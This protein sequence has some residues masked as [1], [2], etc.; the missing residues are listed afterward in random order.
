MTEWNYPHDTDRWNIWHDDWGWYSFYLTC[1]NGWAR[2]LLNRWIRH[3]AEGVGNA[4]M[5]INQ[6]TKPNQIKPAFRPIHVKRQEGTRIC[7]NEFTDASGP[8]REGGNNIYF[9]EKTTMKSSDGMV[10]FED[11]HFTS[12]D[13]VHN[14]KLYMVSQSTRF[15]PTWQY[16]HGLVQR[17]CI[18]NRVRRTHLLMVW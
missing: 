9:E 18:Q 15:D 10:T 17:C 5:T 16:R 6:S 8:I 2:V 14:S 11:L 1:M 4:R 7:N 3:I 13:W 12:D